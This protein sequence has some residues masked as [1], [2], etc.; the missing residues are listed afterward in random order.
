[1]RI[2]PQRHLVLAG[3]VGKMLPQI[4]MEAVVRVVGERVAADIQRKRCPAEEH[5]V[6]KGGVVIKIEM[7]RICPRLCICGN[8]HRAEELCRHAGGN[9]LDRVGKQGIGTGRA[10]VD[11]MQSRV[12]H[13]H[14][15][16]RIGRYADGR[17]GGILGKPRRSVTGQRKGTVGGYQ[18]GKRGIVVLCGDD[19]DTVPG[20]GGDERCHTVFVGG[21]LVGC[22]NGRDAELHYSGCF[23]HETIPF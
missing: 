7:P 19:A 8:V 12:L 2:A 13:R 16:R 15:K 21:Q 11:L 17:I 18:N 9:F 22:R 1:M 14:E 5:F 23:S 3:D 6:L 10:V 20:I 4:E